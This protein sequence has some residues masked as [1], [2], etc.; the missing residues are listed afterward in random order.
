MKEPNF[1]QSE[2][3][4][5]V[6]LPAFPVWRFTWRETEGLPAGPTGEVRQ[7]LT[8]PALHVTEQ[9]QTALELIFHVL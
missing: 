8:F 2:M 1:D 7:S 3:A 4:P 6:R 9:T 5:R